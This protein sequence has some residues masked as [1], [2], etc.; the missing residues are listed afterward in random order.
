MS[1]PMQLPIRINITPK[2]EFMFCANDTENSV[3]VH[4]DLEE[5]TEITEALQDY[6]AAQERLKKLYNE[7]LDQGE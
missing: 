1:E 7:N 4:M 6:E 3:L 5:M 2:N